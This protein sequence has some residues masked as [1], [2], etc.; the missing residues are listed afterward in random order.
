M[1]KRNKYFL[2]NS[3][4]ILEGSQYESLL[5]MSR[6]LWKMLTPSPHESTPT[7]SMMPTKT[8]PASMPSRLLEASVLCNGN[9][10]FK[11]MLRPYGAPCPSW[12]LAIAQSIGARGGTARD[13][14]RP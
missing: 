2:K 13:M 6:D 12:S 5:P 1:H 10:G 7:D 9:V 11:S 3:Y 14:Y 8:T 4:G